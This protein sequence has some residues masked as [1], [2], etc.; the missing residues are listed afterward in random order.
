MQPDLLQQLKDLHLPT[1]PGWWPPAPGWWLL[2]L[3]AIAA[4]VWGYVAFSRRRTRQ[5]PYRVA[6]AELERLGNGFDAGRL[7]THDL[8]HSVSELLKRALIA[9]DGRTPIARLEGDA[10]LAYLDGAAGDTA[11]TTG[12]GALL[13]A[14]RFDPAASG[15]AP[16][17]IAIVDRL[18][19]RMERGR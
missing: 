16:R 7:T 9:R 5:R 15:D 12:A 11:F 14:R 4:V 10:W 17:L 6:R 18:L 1:V 2:L 13:G 3:L 8:A 19:A